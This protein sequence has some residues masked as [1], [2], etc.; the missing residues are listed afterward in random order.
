MTKNCFLAIGLIL[1]FWSICQNSEMKGKTFL[2]CAL[3]EKAVEARSKSRIIHFCFQSFLKPFAWLWCTRNNW[4]IFISTS[5]SNANH[6]FSFFLI[7]IKMKEGNC[8]WWFVESRCVWELLFPWLAQKLV[9]RLHPT[10]QYGK[11]LSSRN[12]NWHNC[13]FY[14]IC[15]QLFGGQILR[16]P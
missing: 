9:S 2:L 4:R 5:S 7:Y 3:L 15:R 10:Q 16:I 6:L 12:P 11:P 8:P 14:L 13:Q 1:S